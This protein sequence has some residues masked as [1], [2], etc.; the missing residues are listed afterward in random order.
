MISSIPS[1]LLTTVFPALE[2][3]PEPERVMHY[4]ALGVNSK[5]AKII[6]SRLGIPVK[7]DKETDA[8]ILTVSGNQ[9][10]RGLILRELGNLGIKPR[11]LENISLSP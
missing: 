5:Q 9:K 4:I 2:Q 3:F 6:E 11:S 7:I 1:H 10:S 8:I